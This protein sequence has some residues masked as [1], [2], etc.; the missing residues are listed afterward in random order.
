MIVINNR[1][2]FSI[3]KKLIKLSYLHCSSKN[4]VGKSN[5]QN[6]KVI[7][8]TLPD[9]SGNPER[10]KKSSQQ[11][12][13]S[14]TNVQIA[15]EDSTE[16]ATGGVLY[17]KVFLEISQ[18]SQ[19]YTCSRVSL[20]IK[21]QTWG[22]WELLTKALFLKKKKTWHFSAQRRNSATLLKAALLQGLQLY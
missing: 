21:L 13:S 7:K 15:G 18:N 10:L 6:L 4:V 3:V 8:N 22:Y 9:K 17:E 11:L 5:K 14:S 16:A 1:L 20:L 19:E 2:N 12:E